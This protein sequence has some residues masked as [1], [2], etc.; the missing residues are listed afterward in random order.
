VTGLRGEPE[1]VTARTSED[2][3]P[4]LPSFFDASAITTLHSNRRSWRWF[5]SPHPLPGFVAVG[6]VVVVVDV[7]VDVEVDVE[8]ELVVEVDVV[9]VVEYSYSEA[10][11]ALSCQPVVNP[12]RRPIERIANSAIAENNAIRP[13]RPQSALRVGTSLAT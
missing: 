12:A 8:V 5:L 3:V 13:L 7:D 11:E 6:V 2:A 4:A 10:A 1:S 9:I